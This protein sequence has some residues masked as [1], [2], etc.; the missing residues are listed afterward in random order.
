VERVRAADPVSISSRYLNFACDLRTGTVTLQHGENPLILNA[1]A[2][3]IFPR[4][5]VLASDDNFERAARTG[6][7]DT[8]GLEGE[9]LT[10]TCRDRRRQLDLEWRLMLLR[11]RPG[12]V[13]EVVAANASGQDVVLRRTEPLRALLDENAGCYFGARQALTHG[14]MHHDPGALVELGQPFREF[15]SHSN[16][17]LCR[18]HAGATLVIGHLDNTDAEGQV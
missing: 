13:F 16:A 10:V 8:P 9:M 5:E 4:G 14:Y 11:D 17:A 2:A 15:T 3:A 1:T 7:L 18:S 12:A 6:N